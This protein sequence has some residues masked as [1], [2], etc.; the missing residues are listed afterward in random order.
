MSKVYQIFAG[1]KAHLAD[2]LPTVTAADISV[3]W[4]DDRVTLSSDLQ[5]DPPKLTISLYGFEPAPDLKFSGYFQT[6]TIDIPNEVATLRR[7]PIPF[8]AFIQIDTFCRNSKDDWDLLEPLALLLAARVPF[9]VNH[10]TT[11][12]PQLLTYQVFEEPGDNQ[13]DMLDGDFHKVLRFH[14]PVWFD[15]PRDVEEVALVLGIQINYADQVI[16]VEETP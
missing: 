10:G 9:E 11:G 3:A 12:A 13:D 4:K 14:T 6:E 5:T 7:L 8:R 16:T 1:L 15:D 2:K